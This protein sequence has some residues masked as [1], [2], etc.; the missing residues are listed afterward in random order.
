MNEK[1][2]T[3]L[4][5]IKI[6]KNVISSIAIEATTQ[7]PGVLR[8][9]GDFKSYFLELLGKKS[10]GTIKIEFDKN[11]EATITIPLVVKYGYNIPETA[12]RVQDNV[13]TAIEN[14]ANINI[15]EVNVNV[16]GIDKE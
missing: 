3:E 13:K 2:S 4:G 15:K 14:T 9:A 6:H 10:L 11:N 8:I 7:I 12:S 5:E 16:Q 1:T